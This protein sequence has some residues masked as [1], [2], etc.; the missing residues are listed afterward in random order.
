MKS[1]SSSNKKLSLREQYDKIRKIVRENNGKSTVNKRKSK[2]SD[3]SDI[4]YNGLTGQLYMK[5]K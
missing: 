5:F 3:Y 2:Y 1:S 4:D